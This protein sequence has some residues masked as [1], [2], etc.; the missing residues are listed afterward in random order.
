[1][2][3]A[4]NG[5]GPRRNGAATTKALNGQAGGPARNGQSGNG[6]AGN[7]HAGNGHAG[8]G[9]SAL[10]AVRAPDEAAAQAPDEA[11]ATVAAQAPAPDEGAGFALLCDSAVRLAS[12]LPGPLQRISLRIGDAAIDIEFPG[13]PVPIAPAPVYVPAGYADGPGAGVLSAASTGP[14]PAGPAGPGLDAPGLSGPD[15]LP[16]TGLIVRAPLVGTYFSASAPGAD[17]FVRAG[18]RVEPGQQIAIVEAM[19]LMNAVTAPC[20]GV[21]R[22][23]HADNGSSVEYDEPLLTLLPDGAP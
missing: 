12:V 1:M 21:V 6:H 15:A 5:R 10:V 7:G 16:D 4:D 2:T 8:N 18:D 19:K 23:I 9:Q 3:G 14:V 22:E 13:P 20:A 11:A 17:T